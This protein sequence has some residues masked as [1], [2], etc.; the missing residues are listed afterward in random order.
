M[1]SYSEPKPGILEKAKALFGRQVEVIVRQEQKLVELVQ[2][3]V[4]KLSK[5]ANNPKV[6]KFIQPIQIFIRMI[7]AHFRGEHKIAFSTLG[8]IVLALVYFLSPIDLIPDFLGVIGFADDLSVVLAVYAKVKD[9]VEQFL[10]WERTQ[11]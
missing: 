2:S 3:V 1:N 9:E 7:K 4:A 11:V 8:L 5:V 10:E 6:Q